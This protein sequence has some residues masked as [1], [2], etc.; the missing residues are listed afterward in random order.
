MN[1]SKPRPLWEEEVSI[2]EGEERY[3]TRRQLG[4]F[5]ALTSLGMFAGNVWIF[6]RSLMRRPLE[7]K[8]ARVATASE[9]PKGG[10]RL[11]NYP[12]PDDPCLMVRTPDDKIVAYSQKCTHLSCAVIYSKERNRIEC[13]CHNGLFAVEDGHV[14]GGPP[15]RP[16]PRIELEQRGDELYAIGVRESGDNS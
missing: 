1:G 15:P 10:V 3:V 7:Y 4:K 12:G 2:R 16:L 13:P 8:A 14:L 11:F 9:L 6:V 5:L